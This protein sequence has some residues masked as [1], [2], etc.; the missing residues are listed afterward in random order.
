MH[1]TYVTRNIRKNEKRN[2]ERNRVQNW[3]FLKTLVTQMSLSP[4]WLSNKN[5]AL[6][7]ITEYPVAELIV[8]SGF[9]IVLSLEQIVMG[10]CVAKNENKNKKNKKEHGHEHK[11]HDSGKA[12]TELILANLIFIISAHE[13]RRWLKISGLFFDAESNNN[14]FFKIPNFYFFSG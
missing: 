6:P 7:D 14:F 3:Y 10:V 5:N 11:N 13:R 2:N 1:F 9:F 8:A 12:K 4:T